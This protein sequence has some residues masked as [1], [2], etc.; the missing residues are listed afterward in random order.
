MTELQQQIEQYRERVEA[1]SRQIGQDPAE[2]DP[3]HF[4]EQ[5]VALV[6]EV[7]EA[8]AGLQAVRDAAR[9]VA[10]SFQQR[11]PRA[12]PRESVRTDHLGSATYRERGWSA[13]SAGE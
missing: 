13:L 6:R 10:R 12:R 5:I 3:R 2:I 9:P 8:I 7:D 1:L 11:F 4:R